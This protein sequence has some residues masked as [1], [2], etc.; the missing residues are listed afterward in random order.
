MSITL[1]FPSFGQYIGTNHGSVTYC[2]D[3]SQSTYE[4]AIIVD[5]NSEGLIEE[6]QQ[7]GVRVHDWVL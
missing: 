7:V 2:I 3:T 5:F 1:P 4:E 6:L